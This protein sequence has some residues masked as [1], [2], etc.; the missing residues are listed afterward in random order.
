M[1]GRVWKVAGWILVGLAVAVALV[2]TATI[3]WRPFLGPRAR[4]L[5]NRTFERTPERLYRGRYL[6]E[7][8]F[9]CIDC[10]SEHDFK[11]S[12]AE[13]IHDAALA[14]AEIIMKGL[15]GRIVAPN[16]TSDPETGLGR[17]SDDE[18]ARAIRE[19]IGRDGRAL[20]PMMPYPHYR[21]MSDDDLA[22]VIVYLRSLPPVRNA[23]PAT[24]LIFPV[25]YLIRSAPQPIT[26]PVPA[27]DVSTP[28]KRGAYLVEVSGCADCHNPVDR[29]GLPIPGMEFSGGQVFEG[30]W[31]RVASAN[32]TPDPTGI[33][34]Y[35]ETLFMQAI[36][37]GAVRTRQLNPIMPWP[38]M[39]KQTDED[40]QAIFAYLKTLKPV[41]HRVDNT[42][43]PTLCRLC[44][45]THGLG[46][47]N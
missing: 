11:K 18:I 25:K 27:P 8:A 19:G 3:G 9:G 5:T 43:T 21:S 32:L 4:T 23:L 22:S 14:G 42:E 28:E 17:W 12:D 34:Y 26:S 15:P 38:L 41:Q 31:G 30:P 39:R 1:N 33:P 36:R 47:K 35:D 7:S 37:T 13:V 20:F 10:H 40:L 44:G 29:N 45:A 24:E 46:D 2:I 16:L 6:A